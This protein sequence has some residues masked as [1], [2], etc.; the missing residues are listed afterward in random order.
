MAP[1]CAGVKWLQRAGNVGQHRSAER[2]NTL[3]S[4]VSAFWIFLACFSIVCFFQIDGNVESIRHQ[5]ELLAQVLGSSSILHAT[6]KDSG[7]NLRRAVCIA[8]RFEVFS[9]SLLFL[10]QFLFA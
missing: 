4:F 9:F 2:V 3:P 7:R 1:A 10:L 6:K 5:Q 8:S